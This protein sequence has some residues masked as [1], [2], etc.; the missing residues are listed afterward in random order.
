LRAPFVGVRD[1]EAE[2]RAATSGGKLIGYVEKRRAVARSSV[3]RVGG[4]YVDI[5]S[6]RSQ[7][8][9]LLQRHEDRG[10]LTRNELGFV[11]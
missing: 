7:V 10:Q 5:P 6:I 1:A 3:L 4:K 9:E 8:R 11:A 2:T